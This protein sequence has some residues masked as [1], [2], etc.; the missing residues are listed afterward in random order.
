M[1]RHLCAS[2][3]VSDVLIVDGLDVAVAVSPVAAITAEVMK[4]F[5]CRLCLA[6]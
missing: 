6:Q 5:A 1:V 2:F 4:H 3:V